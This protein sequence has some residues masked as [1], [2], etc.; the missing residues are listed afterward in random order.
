MKPPGDETCQVVHA[1]QILMKHE[2]VSSPPPPYSSRNG[3]H[4]DDIH[5][6]PAERHVGN[7]MLIMPVI[8]SPESCPTATKDRFAAPEDVASSDQRVG[9]QDDWLPQ[10]APQP[11][12]TNM[13]RVSYRSLD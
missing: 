2:S 5:S 10:L 7:D 13:I 9:H 4:V 8:V 6:F 12:L 1:S 11:D 3:S